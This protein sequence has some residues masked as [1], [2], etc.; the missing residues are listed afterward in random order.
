MIQ[1]CIYITVYAMVLIGKLPL[2][3]ILKI[4]S[5]LAVPVFLILLFPISA[6]VQQIQF[7]MD[8]PF[9]ISYAFLNIGDGVIHV[10]NGGAL[11]SGDEPSVNRKSHSN[12]CVNV[13]VHA[14]NQ[15]QAT[16]CTCL[17]SS[18]SLHSWA[19]SFGPNSL[20]QNVTNQAALNSINN[21]HYVVV[22]LFASRA[23]GISDAASCPS[24]A[25][26]NA[27]AG[28]L[29]VWMNSSHPT[30]TGVTAITATP[31]TPATLSL[32]EE[33]RMTNACAFNLT[34][35]SQKQCPGC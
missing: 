22:K 33:T 25:T 34:Q 3:M 32:G 29:I 20:L 5:Y 14:P 15:Q 21:D 9:Q 30:N 1:S 31:F 17:V 11:T 8:T 26:P 35:G 24:P 12:V 23:S 7:T 2:C 18:N 16:C 28:G 13:Y 27:A 10:T 4:L 19:I 6:F